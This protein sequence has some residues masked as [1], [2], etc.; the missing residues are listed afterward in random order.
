[1]QE[2]EEQCVWMGDEY[3]NTHIE[4]SNS[5]SRVT[6]DQ[7]DLHMEMAKQVRPFGLEPSTYFP[8]WNTNFSKN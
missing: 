7:F 1:M 6:R 5:S 2:A 8:K 4:S 3:S